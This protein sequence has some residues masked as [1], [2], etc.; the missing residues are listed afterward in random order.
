MKYP[1]VN[2]RIKA[3]EELLSDA[4]EAIGDKMRDEDGKGMMPFVSA[5]EA[6][7]R[8]LDRELELKEI[9]DKGRSQRK[10]YVIQFQ[11]TQSPTVEA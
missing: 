1:D 4:I 6:C 8:R 2:S 7:G 11:D 9:L 5:M 3:L 10:G